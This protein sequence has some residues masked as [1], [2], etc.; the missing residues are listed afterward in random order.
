MQLLAIPQNT[1]SIRAQTVADRLA[2]G[3]RSGSGNGG[4]VQ[5]DGP[6]TARTAEMRESAVPS[7]SASPSIT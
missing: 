4:S 1:K 3:D 5:M 7:P 6:T 2:D